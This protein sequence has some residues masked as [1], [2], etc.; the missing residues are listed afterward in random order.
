M[1][2]KLEQEGPLLG[3]LV[4][5]DSLHTP[6]FL[7]LIRQLEERIETGLRRLS[8][9]DRSRD[10]RREVFPIAAIRVACG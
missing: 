5:I 10:I 2:Q 6:E 4:R 9:L 3:V 7:A 8:D 1:A